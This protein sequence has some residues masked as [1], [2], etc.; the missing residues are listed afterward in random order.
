MENEVLSVSQFNALLNQTLEFAYPSVVIEGEV[1][2]FKVNQGKWV[3]FDLKDEESTIGCFMTI[4]NLKVPLEDGMLIKVIATPNLTKWGK[5]SLTVKEIELSG[6]GAVK[7]AFEIL[8]ARFEHEGLFALDRKRPLPQY[9]KKIALIT[10]RQAA[11]FNDF[12]TILNDR[13]VGLE[14]DQA[15]V[16]VQG[17][18]APVQVVRAIDYFNNSA[19]DYDALVVI[20]GGGSAEDLQ[21]FNHEDVVRAVYGSKIP[22]IVAI[23]H[24]DD[25]SLAELAADLRAATPSDAAR[26]LVP[27]KV[28][29][30][31]MIVSTCQTTSQSLIGLIRRVE[32]RI[33]RVNH[34]F[35]RLYGDIKFDLARL[36]Q[37]NFHNIDRMIHLQYEKLSALT[38]ILISLDP[39]AILARGYSVATIKG[40]AIT[41]ASQ[42]KLQDQ[43]VLQ[44]HQGK[45]ELRL[46]KGEANVRVNR[47]RP[48]SEK[49]QQTQLRF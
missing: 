26:R 44:L 45:A 41:D 1:A 17:V 22:C 24:E 18:D 9:P 31:N 28:Q 19:T 30:L 48:Q 7:K 40:K 11:A 33:E 37:Q 15:Q 20:R 38:R 35:A 29:A 13:W 49:G 6:E 42:I 14:I 43:V 39:R 3:F 5:F 8:K 16:Q 36:A 47:K 27:D 32:A 25:V 12:V 10:S 46:A 34:N 4:Y 21:A 23:G 2:S